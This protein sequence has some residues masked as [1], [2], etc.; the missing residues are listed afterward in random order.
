MDHKEEAAAKL[1]FAAQSQARG[2]DPADTITTALIGIGHALMAIQGCLDREPTDDE[3]AG[4]VKADEIIHAIECVA[5][6]IEELPLNSIR[7]ELA[8]LRAAIEEAS[9]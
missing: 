3:M 9:R 1:R 8:D 5:D 2:S 7:T 6:V 4:D